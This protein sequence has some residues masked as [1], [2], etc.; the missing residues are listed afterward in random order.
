MASPA[1]TINYNSTTGQFNGGI[2]L[3]SYFTTGLY[4][5]KVQTPQYLRGLIP[6]IQTITAGQVNTMPYVVLI[7]GDIN[8]DNQINITDYN[9]LMACYSDLEPPQDP[10]L[11]SQYTVNGFSLADLNDDGAVNEFD[12]NLFIRE[13]T[14][15]GGQ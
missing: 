11:C 3:G 4:M 15:I 7:A 5:V 6:G 13:L 10:A 1:G 2:D 14:N 12:Y 8:G 9:I